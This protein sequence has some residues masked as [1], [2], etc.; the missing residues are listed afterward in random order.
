MAGRSVVVL[1]RNLAGTSS[2]PESVSSSSSWA[3]VRFEADI[4]FSVG[5]DSEGWL[6][7]RSLILR[8]ELLDRRAG[9]GV[10]GPISLGR[11]WSGFTIVIGDVIKAQ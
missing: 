6:T 4:L 10:F 5:L 9:A 8:P 2:M 3:K 1:G 7:L 11:V